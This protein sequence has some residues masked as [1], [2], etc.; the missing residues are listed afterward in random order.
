MYHYE[1]NNGI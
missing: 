1:C